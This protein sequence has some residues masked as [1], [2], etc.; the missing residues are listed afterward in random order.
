MILEHKQTETIEHGVE[1]GAVSKKGGGGGG[2]PLASEGIVDCEHVSAQQ[3]QQGANSPHA[4][5]QF[6]RERGGLGKRRIGDELKYCILS[7][8]IWCPDSFFPFFSLLCICKLGDPVKWSCQ[9]PDQEPV[10]KEKRLLWV[11]L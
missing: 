4:G 7:Y 1:I 10:A 9:E 11:L 3:C 6:H 2:A 8:W 5:N